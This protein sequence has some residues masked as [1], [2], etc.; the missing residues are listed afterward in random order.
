MGSCPCRAAVLAHGNAAVLSPSFEASAAAVLGGAL[1]GLGTFINGGCV[2]GTV[3][4]IASGNLSFTRALQVLRSALALARCRSCLALALF[5]WTRRERTRHCSTCSLDSSVWLRLLGVSRYRTRAPASR[6]CAWPSPACFPMADFARYD[7]H[8]R[9]G[10]VALCDR[11]A[12]VLSGSLEAAGKLIWGQEVM[13][14]SRHSRPSCVICWS[15]YRWCGRRPLCSPPIR[16][17]PTRPIARWRHSH[18]VCNYSNTGGN[19]SLLLSALPSLAMHGAVAYLAMLGVQIFLCAPLHALQTAEQLR[20]RNAAPR[21][22]AW[23]RFVP[24]GAQLDPFDRAWT[25]GH[26]DAEG[27]L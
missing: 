24:Q 2:F 12:L 19:D 16:R 6:N 17:R 11:N 23:R 10:R 27:M 15:D 20:R 5:P 7:D 13:F 3:A 14:S 1:Y 9:V 25:F 8:W 26:A 4:R 21:R 22:G 18:R